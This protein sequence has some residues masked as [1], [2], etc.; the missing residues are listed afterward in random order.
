MAKSS[1]EV[2]ELFLLLIPAKSQAR[3]RSAIMVASHSF[4][5][6]TLVPTLRSTR[7]GTSA[8]GTCTPPAIVTSQPGGRAAG[9]E[10]RPSLMIPA[11]AHRISHAGSHQSIDRPAQADLLLLLLLAPLPRATST[12]YGAGT[13]A[14][15]CFAA[16]AALGLFSP[17]P[18]RLLC[19]PKGAGA[20]QG[21]P[22]P[23]SPDLL[24]VAADKCS[25]SPPRYLGN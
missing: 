12:K 8:P 18:W 25:V 21:P 11:N 7:A 24:R 16:P 17:L 22:L 6:S 4:L 20:G 13:P 23:D 15:S 19:R 1:P 14:Y 2:S 5:G 10:G 9:G 3:P